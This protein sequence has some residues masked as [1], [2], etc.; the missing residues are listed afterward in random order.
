MW[1]ATFPLRFCCSN[2]S[3]CVKDCFVLSHAFSYSINP[4][5]SARTD[6]VL[7]KPIAQRRSPSG[8]SFFLQ[9]PMAM[10]SQT[11]PQILLTVSVPRVTLDN[12][13]VWFWTSHRRGEDRRGKAENIDE[14]WWLAQK[15]D[16]RSTFCSRCLRYTV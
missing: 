3:W 12:T 5:R 4:F 2:S 11:K 16:A 14:G 8:P 1:P 13:R 15:S 9:R 6:S 10:V 7:F